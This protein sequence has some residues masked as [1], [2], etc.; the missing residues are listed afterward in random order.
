M[1]AA[2]HRRPAYEVARRLLRDGRE[3]EYVTQEALLAA[4]LE[5]AR[6]REPRRF[7][8]WLC[9][10]VANLAKM[11]LGDPGWGWSSLE[12]LNG[13]RR[14]P[15]GVLQT[16]DP[17]PD[18]V[19]ETHELLGI[20]R[21]AL[22]LLPPGQREAVLLLYLDGL[23]CQEVAALLGS[24]T[25]AVRVR[26]HRARTLLRARLLE[27]AP[28]LA[29]T[30]A[31][32]PLIT[33]SRKDRQTMIAVSIE[34]VVVRIA[35]PDPERDLLRHAGRPLR[36]VLLREKEGDRRLPI[37]IGQAEGDALAF[38]L[39][40]EQPPRP[41]SADLTARLLGL[42]GARIEQVRVDRLEENTFFS[43]MTVTVDGTTHEI[44]ARPSDALN[45]AARLGAPILVAEELLRGAG[46]DA[47][48][49]AFLDGEAVKAHE[50]MEETLPEGEW[51]SLTPELVM[52][53]NPPPGRR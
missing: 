46:A 2:R 34:D 42:A 30:I 40:S 49:F 27:A 48:P 35:K 36:I 14:V 38:Q 11:R 44:D 7:R 17:S 4:Y 24:S 26:L 3:A 53:L 37:W 21:A 10:I 5:L 51:R 15:A 9:G 19:A 8:A 32:R 25:G 33:Q 45:L 43:T 23:S 18:Q 50:R 28:E 47:D 22:D 20:V 16:A 31:H 6:L 1:L 52:T 39:A 12:D 41:T 13:G 29:P